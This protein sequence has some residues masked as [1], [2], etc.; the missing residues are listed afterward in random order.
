KKEVPP[1][2][3]KAAEEKKEE[4][5]PEAKKSKK[6]KKIK[7]LTLDEVE[8]KLKSVEATMK[9]TSSKYAQHLLQRREELLQ[10]KK[11][12]EMK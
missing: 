9:G 3:A 12:E 8:E 1:E 6:S 5:P 7:K 2:K 11:A 4:T 10:K